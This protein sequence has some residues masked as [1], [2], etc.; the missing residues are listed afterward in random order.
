MPKVNRKQALQKMTMSAGLL[1]L[2][3][4]GGAVPSVVS[5]T[6]AKQT[7]ELLARKVHRLENLR[8]NCCGYA[9]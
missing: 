8:T 5:E 9:K 3:E 1:A 7:N 4:I 6:M 2:S